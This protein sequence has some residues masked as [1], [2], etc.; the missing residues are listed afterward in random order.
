MS[1]EN[2]PIFLENLQFQSQRSANVRE[3]SIF[4]GDKKLS[5][6]WKEGILLKLKSNADHYPTEQSKIAFVYSM[7]DTDCQSHLHR[8]IKN[9]VLNF[10]SVEIMMN[11]LT[12]LFDDPNRVRDA[13]ARLHSNFQRNKSFS[14]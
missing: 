9:G 4:N 6:I 8:S 13:I 7:L 14:S 5:P 12:V 10:D 1:L 3:G 2:L 11:E